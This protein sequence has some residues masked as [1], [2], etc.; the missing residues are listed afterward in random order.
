M[1]R[2]LENHV[3]HQAA[4]PARGNSVQIRSKHDLREATSRAIK[5]R[6][7][8]VLVVGGA[9]Y[10]GSLLV[11]RLLKNG[12]RVRVLDNLLYGEESLRV[13]RGN[14]DF[15]LIVS[16]CRYLPCVRRAMFG[17]ETVIHLAAIV[18]DRA[19]EQD[20]ELAVTT[21]YAAS[22]ILAKVANRCGV[23]RF[24][25]ASSCSVYGC[26]KSTVDEQTVVRPTSLYGWTKVAS[27][28]LLLKACSP[29]FHPSILRF[30]TAFGLGHRRRFDLVVNALAA[31][32]YKQGMITIHNGHCWRPFIHVRDTVEA[33]LRV[34]EAPEHLVSGEIFNVGDTRLNHTLDEIAQTMQQVFPALR[35]EYIDNSERRSYRVNC[36][37]L[38]MRTGF[39]ACYSLSDGIE[40]IKRALEQGEITDYTDARYDNER[41]LKLVAASTG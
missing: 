2:D 3:W 15:E 1:P 21:N 4:A 25:F 11:E 20:R 7:G 35:V 32:S 34:M 23:A 24:L 12:Y 6:R 28:R 33:I 9:G 29:S 13:V 41:Y 14:L 18:G 19:C 8:L 10:I 39:H 40:E 36:D 22:R 16:D 38:R 26:S 37:K 27:E 17:V 31:K 5:P 30:A